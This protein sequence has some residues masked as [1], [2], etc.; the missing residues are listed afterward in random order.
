[1]TASQQEEG[2]LLAALEMAEHRR[3]NASATHVPTG[4]NFET[5]S[6]SLMHSAGSYTGSCP[7][8]AKMRD[9]C[10][11][12]A[13][14]MRGGGGGGGCKG[15]EPAGMPCEQS[16][17]QQPTYAPA[18][19]HTRARTPLESL[20]PRAT[21][22]PSSPGTHVAQG[23]A[24]KEFHGGCSRVWDAGWGGVEGGG[25]G[26]G[27]RGDGDMQRVGHVQASTDGKGKAA[28]TPPPP[29]HSPQLVLPQHGEV[30]TDG[31]DMT[32]GAAS[33]P[34]PPPQ[35]AT[36]R[37]CAR[38]MS[39]MPAAL[40][41]LPPP[42]LPPPPGSP[43][44]VKK[45]GRKRKEGQEADRYGFA[46]WC[47]D[48]SLVWFRLVWMTRGSMTV[49]TRKHARTRMHAHTHLHA[50][51]RM[52]TR[53]ATAKF[54]HVGAKRRM[55][56]M[57]P[58]L[59]SLPSRQRPRPVRRVRCAAH[60]RLLRLLQSRAYPYERAHYTRSNI[61]RSGQYAHTMRSHSFNVSPSR[62]LTFL[63]LF[64]PPPS[65]PPSPVLSSSV[66]AG[67]GEKRHV[68]SSGCL[69]SSSFARVSHR[70]GRRPR[71]AS[72]SSSSS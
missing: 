7:L 68:P 65:F 51:T 63:P 15:Q 25:S 12:H 32:A 46:W 55:R 6:H 60:K 14:D 52:H 27:G 23:C 26:G 3:L 44:S 31:K 69:H 39:P 5:P 71:K 40:P 62:F 33:P 56:R 58:G 30:W 41:P 19:G 28:G 48:D 22:P 35:L 9:A 57:Q 29:P 11:P 66:G 13:S 53:T 37:H 72:S 70:H 4:A 34:P 20:Y 64:P 43:P 1:M 38:P 49:R 42:P 18:P 21:L 2:I 61:P 67:A 24:I 8:P 45:G 54:S 47:V 59:A 36:P 16:W 10:H 17:L 50:H